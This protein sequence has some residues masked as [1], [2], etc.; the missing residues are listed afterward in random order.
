MTGAVLAL[1]KLRDE[2]ERGVAEPLAAGNVTLF[3]EACAIWLEAYRYLGKPRLQPRP[4]AQLR[5]TTTWEKARNQLKLHILRVIPGDVRL[6][7]LAPKDFESVIDRMLEEGRAQATVDTTLSVL[8][9]LGRDLETL[10]FVTS[11]PAEKLSSTWTSA[12]REV[13]ATEVPSAR[14]VEKLAKAMDAEWPGRGDIIRFFAYSGLRF[15]EAAALRWTDIDFTAHTISVTKTAVF[16]SIGRQER[17]RTKTQ[18][19][20]RDVVLL[21]DAATALR[22]IKRKQKTPSH[23][24]L[25]GARGGPLDY[26]LWRKHLTEAKK[27]SGVHVNAHGLRH[28]FAT[29]TLAAGVPVQEVSRYLGHSTTRITET[30]YRKFIKLDMKNR[31]A[32]IDALVAKTKRN[33]KSS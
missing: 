3:S 32:E 24:V 15:Q 4:G 9:T 14:S 1:D 7:R 10:G 31:A 21:A 22:R 27:V 13:Q 25:A 12:N 19:G 16:T 20:H 18:A 8:R 30:R 2:V 17:E 26:R 28:Y 29:M 33:S 6:R 5:P 23:Y 11:N